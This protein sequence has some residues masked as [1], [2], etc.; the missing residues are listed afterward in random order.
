LPDPVTQDKLVEVR[1]D[2]DNAIPEYY[3]GN[4]NASEQVSIYYAKRDRSPHPVPDYYDLRVDAYG[5]FSNFGWDSYSD[6]WYAYTKEAVHS[7]FWTDREIAILMNEAPDLVPLAYEHGHCHGMAATSV[8]YF[9]NTDMIPVPYESTFNVPKDAALDAVTRYHLYQV[10]DIASDYHPSVSEARDSLRLYLRDQHEPYLLGSEDIFGKHM[11]TG[12]KAVEVGGLCLAYVYDNEDDLGPGL[13]KIRPKFGVLDVTGEEYSAFGKESLDYRAFSQ[14]PDLFA[15]GFPRFLQTSIIGQPTVM[16]P[17][18]RLND[19][20]RTIV[21]GLWR[22]LAHALFAGHHNLLS[23]GCPV[24]A[25]IEDNHGRRIGFVGDTLVN[26]IPGASVDTS[27]QMEIYRLPD[28]L[29]YT[30]S[31]AA[32][33]TGFMRI[34]LALPLGDSLTRVATFDSIPLQSS[35]KTQL[36]FTLGDT[37]FPMAVDWDGGGSTDTTIPP[38]FNDTIGSGSSAVREPVTTQPLPTRFDLQVSSPLAAG[39]ATA[40]KYML[41][42]PATVRMVVYDAFG[43]SVKTLAAGP[44]QAGVYTVPW[45]GADDRG[46]SVARGAYFVALKAG[47]ERAQR[48]LVLVR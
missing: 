6:A 25:L 35:T 11:T 12:Y 2:P 43:R 41:P 5:Q 23:I 1:V 21:W 18:L 28:I 13:V 24:N 45:N 42:K 26:E 47:P 38:D 4:N 40:I 27:Y 20:I 19:A 46:K 39:P 30:T 14:S 31:I 44:R 7:M 34:C 33:D 37:L 15:Y 22:D 3:E 10:F 32:F 29:V 36:V 9:D 48:K 17:R 8:L 16:R